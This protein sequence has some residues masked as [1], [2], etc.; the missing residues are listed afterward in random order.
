M[1]ERLFLRACAVVARIRPVFT[2][3]G[4]DAEKHRR[5]CRDFKATPPI[6]KR[7]RI[8]GQDLGKRR[9][10]IDRTNARPLES[11]GLGLRYDRHGVVVRL[12]CR[13]HAYSWLHDSF[14]LESYC[15]P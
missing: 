14:H 12:C 5:F 10:P 13:R 7:G 15:E 2:D 6:H 11:R 4:Y 9:W 8:H 3:N 1:L